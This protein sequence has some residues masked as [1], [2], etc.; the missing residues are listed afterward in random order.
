MRSVL[1]LSGQNHSQQTQG[2][3][4]IASRIR[5]VSLL[6]QK[7]YQQ[8][9][10]LWAELQR[11]FSV[12]GVYVSPR[13]HITYHIA[14]CY[15]V[16]SLEAVLQRFAAGKTSFKVR[17]GGLGIFTGPQ[18]VLYIPVVRSPELS[19][20]HEALWQEILSSGA[21]IE[22]YYH[23]DRWVPHITVGIGDM[24][25]DNL[26]QIVRYL[27]ERDFN[28]EITIE[29]IVLVHNLILPHFGFILRKLAPGVFGTRFSHVALE[30][31]DARISMDGQATNHKA[32][33]IRK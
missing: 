11:K 15:K 6:D 23:P 24:N 31:G 9:E 5:V 10:N 26:S 33:F 12:K 22:D 4:P 3:F 25:K 30:A 7:H 28:W 21:D 20:F 2:P 18:P 8:V 16:K 27:A 19:Q 29:S 1:T 32:Q 17:T 14:T 13:P